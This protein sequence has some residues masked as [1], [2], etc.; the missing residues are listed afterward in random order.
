MKLIPNLLLSLLPIL[1]WC[2]QYYFSKKEKLLKIFKKHWTCYYGDWI[3]LPINFLFI[4]S[5]QLDYFIIYFLIISLISNIIIHKYWINQN[6]KYK[7]AS[8][9]FKEGKLKI[10]GYV[11]LIFSTIQMTIILSLLFLN[12]IF[13]YYFIQLFLLLFFGLIMLYGSYKT[14][15][16]ISFLDLTISLTFII[17]V[18][19]RSILLF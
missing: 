19:I 7:T 11:H 2:L 17:F 5:I 8:H 6:K 1:S 13:P 14:N 16:K 15:S 12:P 3:F 4:F 10:P 9:L 18:I